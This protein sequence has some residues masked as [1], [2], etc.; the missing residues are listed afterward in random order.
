[1]EKDNLILEELKDFTEDSFSN[2]PKEEK[3]IS[4]EELDS[5]LTKHR[6][7]C[8]SDTCTVMIYAMQLLGISIGEDFLTTSGKISDDIYTIEK[9]KKC[10]Q[11]ILED[12]SKNGFDIERFESDVESK[13]T[14]YLKTV[15]LVNKKLTK[16]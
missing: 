16:K 5:I 12:T 7:T 15:Q 4:R 6:N 11:L 13:E 2:I 9:I 3:P 8:L 1:M 10:F 14:D